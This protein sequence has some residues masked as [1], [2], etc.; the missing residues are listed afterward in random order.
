MQLSALALPS[1]PFG[2]P[3]TA[4]WIYVCA[5]TLL[6]VGLVK[7]VPALRHEHGIDKIMPFGRLFYAIPLAVFGSEHFTITPVIAG[8]VPRWIPAPTF[9]VYLVGAGFIC[10]ALSITVL[11]R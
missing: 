2:I 6:V 1:A 4:F 3:N 10:A 7:I 8:L 5:S 11:V 9:W